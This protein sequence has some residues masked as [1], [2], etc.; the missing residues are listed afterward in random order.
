MTGAAQQSTRDNDWKGEDRRQ[1]TEP[2]SRNEFVD[3]QRGLYERLGDQDKL[4]ANGARMFEKLNTAMFAKDENN[5]FES[6]GVMTVMQKISRH[7]DSVCLFGQAV[8]KAGVVI[9]MC[10]AVFAALKSMGML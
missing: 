5:E 4:L 9:I 1:T 6:P 10:G 2:V 7:I 8:K 3:F